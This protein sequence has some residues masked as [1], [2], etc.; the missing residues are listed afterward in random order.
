MKT[1]FVYWDPH[2]V[3]RAWAE[4][5]N[6]KFTPFAPI[7]ILK[8]NGL[9][10][11][12]GALIKGIFLPRADTYLLESPM[13][14]TALLPRLIFSKPKI[15][16]INSDPFFLSLRNYR[17]ITKKYFDW[18]LKFIDLIVSTSPM[19]RGLAEKYPRTPKKTKHAVVPI[20]IDSQKFARITPDA[21][22]QNFCFIGPHLNKQKGVDRLISL[23][24]KLNPTGTL[25][26]IG[27][28]TPEIASLARKD[29]RILITGRIKDPERILK[30][31]A[32][33]LNLAR[34]EPAGA[35]ILEAMAAGFVPVVSKD[36]GVAPIVAKLGK[37][38]VVDPDSGNLASTFKKFQTRLSD[39][40]L[41][42]K[43]R[44]LARKFT[45]AASIAAFNRAAK[46]LVGKP[47]GRQLQKLY[48]AILS[49]KYPCL[50]MENR[51]LKT[52][53]TARAAACRKQT[54]A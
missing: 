27:T 2:R 8:K 53:N 21:S 16:A 54:K 37:E 42:R 10:L 52:S 14:V 47:S 29:E 43:A 22:S 15:I 12:L 17:G 18:T 50:G 9:L 41:S 5:L 13:M 24:K 1:C 39:P 48:K 28:A 6:A 23:F 35:N 19:M 25:F 11:H 51:L 40:A 44:S 26:L 45:P 32:Y 30:Q 20:F 49:E 36:C 33:Y 34:F 4:S 3:H 7:N 38:F 46:F 31:C